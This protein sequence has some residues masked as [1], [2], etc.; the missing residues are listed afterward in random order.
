[1]I[2]FKE[3]DKVILLPSHPW[4]GRE[5]T[6]CTIKRDFNNS[7]PFDKSNLYISYADDPSDGWWLSPFNMI[8]I[9]KV[10][11]VY[12]SNQGTEINV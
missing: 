8:Y 3:G 2:K 5:N 10:S 6:I 11:G 7:N 4:G 9:K 1:M 12:L